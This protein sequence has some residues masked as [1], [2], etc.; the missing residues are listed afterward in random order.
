MSNYRLSPQARKSLIQ[1]S[2]FTK[3]QF[4]EAQRLRYLK[5]LRKRMRAVARQ[6]ESGKHRSEIKPGYYSVYVGKHT[7]YYR[8]QYDRIEIIDVLHQSMEPSLHL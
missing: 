7:L 2:E 5:L 3:E 1:I 6:P 4:G 8:I